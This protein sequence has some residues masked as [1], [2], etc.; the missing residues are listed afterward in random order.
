MHCI[1]P[2]Q[3][4]PCPWCL[5]PFDHLCSVHSWPL[6]LS[7][8][9]ANLGLPACRKVSRIPMEQPVLPE[10]THLTCNSNEFLKKN[11]KQKKPPKKKKFLKKEKNVYSNT[12]PPGL[13][14]AVGLF[15]LCDCVKQRQ[16]IR[17][18]TPP[19]QYA[20]TGM[21]CSFLKSTFGSCCAMD[22]TSLLWVLFSSAET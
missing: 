14:W 4:R 1:V 16:D 21:S 7:P 5:P 2:S 12:S 20:I 15:L 22:F 13:I 6:G 9:L 19:P 18:E 3:T 17:G 10:S 8:L 11:K